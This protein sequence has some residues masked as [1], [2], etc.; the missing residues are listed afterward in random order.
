MRRGTVM[1]ELIMATF[2]IGITTIVLFE[3]LIYS[4]HLSIRANRYAR[5]SQIANQEMEI[6]RAT[7]Y[8]GLVVPYNGSFIGTTDSV[9]ELP[10]G[11][12]NLTLSYDD[13]PTNTIKKAIITI[14]WLE[15]SK[16][17]TVQYSTLVVNNGL[18]Q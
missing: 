6:I 16:T 14:T 17:E 5:A 18:Y 2:L 1:I 7:A 12:A 3:A 9:S 8:S 13:A 4:Q 15:G 11:T 10:G